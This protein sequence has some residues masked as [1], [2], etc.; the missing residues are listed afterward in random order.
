M[1]LKKD[2]ELKELKIHYS[3]YFFCYEIFH[4]FLSLRYKK[5]VIHDF[6]N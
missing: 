3:L 2:A 5:R 1:I 4:Y 6:T